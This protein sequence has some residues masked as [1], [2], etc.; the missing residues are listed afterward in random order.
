[1]TFG[2]T[3]WL[4]RSSSSFLFRFVTAPFTYVLPQCLQ[5]VRASP[6]HFHNRLHESVRVVLCSVSVPSGWRDLSYVHK[7]N[8]SK[9]AVAFY[10][11]DEMESASCLLSERA[12]FGNAR[13]PNTCLFTC[14]FPWS[15]MFFTKSESR[16][17]A[18]I[19]VYAKPINLDHKLIVKYI[20]RYLERL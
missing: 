16:P 9:L 18:G 4:S 8:K 12:G 7:M 11:R 15:Q 1:M 20:G 13:C 19:S 3:S 6:L 17:A 14:A 2:G 5:A 10:I